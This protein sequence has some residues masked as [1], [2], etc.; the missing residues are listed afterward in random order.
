MTTN[1]A[2]SK[3]TTERSTGEVVEKTPVDFLLYADTQLFIE[4]ESTLT[5]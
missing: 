1:R 3:D 5:W 2:S 4:K